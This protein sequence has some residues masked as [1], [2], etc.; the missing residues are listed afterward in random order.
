MAS[1]KFRLF[2]MRLGME[3]LYN[4]L[5]QIKNGEIK[6]TYSHD[7]FVSSDSKVIDTDCSGLVDLWLQN[8]HRNARDEVY[9]YVLQ[10]RDTLKYNITRLYSFDFYDFFQSIKEKDSTNWQYVDINNTLKEGDILAFINPEHKARWGH[11]AVV[12]EEI[13]RSKEKIKVKVIDSSKYHHFDDWHQSDKMGIGS[14]VIELY[15]NNNEI[16][17]VCY[18]PDCMRVR[19][20]CAG[21]L[22]KK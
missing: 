2:S 13:S 22:R 1:V 6:T 7:I 21:R 8:S 17:K 18:G 11:V 16:K 19:A 20:V 12:E 14:G 10:V 15:F 3:Y 5:Q 4:L 9:A